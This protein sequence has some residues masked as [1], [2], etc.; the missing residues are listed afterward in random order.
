MNEEVQRELNQLR[1]ELHEARELAR[2]ETAALAVELASQF[3]GIAESVEIACEPDERR[4]VEDAKRQ[5]VAALK[6]AE[7]F[8]RGRYG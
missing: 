4:A 6:Q 1:D 3:V 2:Q 7:S 8:L 5:I